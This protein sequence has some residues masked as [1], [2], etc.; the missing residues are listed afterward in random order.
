MFFQ[1]LLAPE[2]ESGVKRFANLGLK[3]WTPSGV[4]PPWGSPALSLPLLIFSHQHTDLTAGSASV[5]P[6]RWSSRRQ[7]RS[8][9][10]STASDDL[11]PPPIPALWSTLIN[12]QTTRDTGKQTTN[13]IQFYHRSDNYNCRTLFTCVG[14]EILL[15]KKLTTWQDKSRIESIECH[16]W[17]AILTRCVEVDFCHMCHRSLRQSL[18][19][20]VSLKRRQNTWK[21]ETKDA[22]R[23][24]L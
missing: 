5:G 6:W 10:S 12:R 15:C 4:S 19:L 18:K 23:M 3:N 21:F 17:D 14:F 16:I 22:N 2:S 24:Q 8:P 13:W 20:D 7:S 11:D 9:S 1:F